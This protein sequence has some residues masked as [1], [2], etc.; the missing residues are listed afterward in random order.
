MES[1]DFLYYYNIPKY[2][3][4]SFFCFEEVEYTY[5]PAFQVRKDPQ[6]DQILTQ[7]TDLN[8]HT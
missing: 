3:S 4:A 5:F 2:C 7:N 6:V 1:L 8:T